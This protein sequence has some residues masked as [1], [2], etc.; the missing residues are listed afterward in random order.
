MKRLWI[1][2]ALILALAGLSAAHVLYLRHFTGQLTELL[3]QAQ[4]LVNEDHWQDADE[5]TRQAVSIWENNAFYLHTTLRHEDIDAI[6]TSFQEVLA[7][8]DGQ[9]RQPAEYAAANARLITLL[10]LLLEAELPTL[11]NLL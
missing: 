6:L 7:F 10:D 1:S 4:Q 9:E 2:A 8:L 5:I 3:T 11:K